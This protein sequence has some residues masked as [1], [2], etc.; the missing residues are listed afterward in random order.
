MG[1]HVGMQIDVNGTRL[2]FDV[3]GSALVPE[4]PTMRER[5]TVVLLHGGP[6]SFD[7]SYLKPDFT[8]LSR[9]A[10]VVY[11]DLR[12]HGRS[13]WGDPA[14]WS[15]EVCADDVRAFCDTLGIAKPIV[16]GH[17]L[18]G[19]VA[20]LYAARHPGHASGLVLDSTTGRFDVER[21][22]ET[23]RRLGG[24]EM[25]ETIARVYGGD[26][27]VTAEQWS[28]CWAMFGRW[29][30]GAQEKARII[31]NAPLNPPGL[32]LL[33]RFHCLDQL[34]TIDCPTLVC[35]GALDP[36]TPVAG[37][38]EIVEAMPKGMARLEV[39]ENAGHF[40]WRDNPERYWPLMSEF[41][42]RCAN[43]IRQPA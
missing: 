22:V 2:W 30:P 9:D 14:A 43:P 16:Y 20:M 10:Q 5:P 18:G 25:A 39:I 21:M 23:F 3:E 36:A 29:V 35:S 37:A 42:S 4:G 13:E 1:H 24:D 12:G 32:V 6:G 17:S 8:R 31:V 7:H 19:M 26:E 27:T 33:S 34:G 40:P 15:F 11:L 41:V 28:P 38:R